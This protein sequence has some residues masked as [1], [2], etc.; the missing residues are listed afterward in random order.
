MK[1]RSQDR[2]HDGKPQQ[3]IVGWKCTADDGTLIVQ[4]DRLDDLFDAMPVG[5]YP[6]PAYAD[7]GVYQVRN[8]LSCGNVSAAYR[9]NRQMTRQKNR[10]ARLRGYKDFRHWA[11]VVMALARARMGQ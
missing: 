11:G 6:Q 3:R 10:N 4:H 5:C 8:N 7:C 1:K 2:P 9:G